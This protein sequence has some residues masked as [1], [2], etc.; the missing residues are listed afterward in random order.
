MGSM[1]ACLRC[2]PQATGRP[3]T[4]SHSAPTTTPVSATQ[5]YEKGSMAPS[6]ENPLTAEHTLPPTAPAL[7]MPT[8]G[9]P[10]R[11]SVSDEELRERANALS[12]QW[13]MVPASTK[14]AGLV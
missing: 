9:L 3:D 13:E 1:R 10:E 11:P 8:A 2:R 7:E 5:R 14:S 6:S 4:A 12:R